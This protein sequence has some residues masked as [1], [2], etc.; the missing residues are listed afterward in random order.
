MIHRTYSQRATRAVLGASAIAVGILMPTNIPVVFAILGAALAY[1]GPD[2]RSMAW[3]VGFLIVIELLFSLDLGILSLSYLIAA[4]VLSLAGRLVTVT[5]WATVDGWSVGDALRTIA[6]SLVAAGVMMVGSV[7]VGALYGSGMTAQRIS[8]Y[9]APERLVP[10]AV[11]IT[12]VLLV[13]RRIDT[14]LRRP[15][16]FG[17]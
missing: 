9:M 3:I 2:H 1:E 4:L 17:V 6:A 11:A 16:R 14:P 13:L 12:I 8:V 7:L 15:I 5:P 10:M